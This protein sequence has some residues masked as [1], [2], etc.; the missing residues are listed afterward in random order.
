MVNIKTQR[1]TIIILLILSII[2]FLAGE[3]LI[4]DIIGALAG[5][6]VFGPW[7][8]TIALKNN[9][10]ENIGFVIGALL[11]IIGVVV[12]WVWCKVFKNHKQQVHS[13]PLYELYE[14]TPS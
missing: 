4:T 9:R 7:V 11:S 3:N 6:F 14:E 5:Y 2:T 12:Y 10:N 13:D 8:A 1:I